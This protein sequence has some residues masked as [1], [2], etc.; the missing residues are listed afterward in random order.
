MKITK[1]SIE[2]DNVLRAATSINDTKQTV[3]V[4][5]YSFSNTNSKGDFKQINNT[6]DLKELH[7][8]GIPSAKSTFAIMNN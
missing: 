3:K 2:F 8:I 4:D 7:S 5:N 6:D 1:S